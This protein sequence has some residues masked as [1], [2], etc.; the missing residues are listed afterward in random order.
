MVDVDLAR[1]IQHV[2]EVVSP[3]G[4]VMRFR[5]GFE[6][7]LFTAVAEAAEVP[8]DAQAVDFRGSATS[9]CQ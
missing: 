6:L 1:A 3:A 5:H 9:S 8:G 7:E 2:H 4:V